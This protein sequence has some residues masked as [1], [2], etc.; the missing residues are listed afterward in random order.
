LDGPVPEE[1]TKPMPLYLDSHTIP[2][3]TGDAVA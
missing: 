1:I 2:G 3:V